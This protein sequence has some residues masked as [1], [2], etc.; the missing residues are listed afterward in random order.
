MRRYAS[1]RVKRERLL[2]KSELQM[3]VLLISGSHIGAPVLASSYSLHVQ[4]CVK[5]FGKLLRNCGPQKPET[6]TNCLYIN[7]L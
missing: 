7:L 1:F 4:R 2:R 5:R 3:S 6:W